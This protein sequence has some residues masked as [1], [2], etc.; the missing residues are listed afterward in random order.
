[1]SQI[2]HVV[3][4]TRELLKIHAAARN[5]IASYFTNVKK[6][7]D[8]YISKLL[9]TVDGNNEVIQKYTMHLETLKKKMVSEPVSKSNNSNPP[10]Q[11]QSHTLLDNTRGQVDSEINELSRNIKKCDEDISQIKN[12]IKKISTS[13]K[14]IQDEKKGLVKKLETKNTELQKEN[15][16][17]TVYTSKMANG[18]KQIGAALDEVSV[19][20][21]Q[22]NQVVENFQTLLNIHIDKRNMPENPPIYQPTGRFKVEPAK[23]MVGGRETR[24]SNNGFHE[25]SARIANLTRQINRV[26]A[27]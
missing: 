5:D 13:T 16:E 18:L 4:K 3:N 25:L 7:N 2:E 11:V 10:S 14:K 6:D 22:E 9:V 21:Q 1:M 15:E 19:D 8:I 20:F 23:F 12:N 27:V 24:D 17:S 26:T